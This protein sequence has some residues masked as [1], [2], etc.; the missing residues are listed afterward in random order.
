M[1]WILIGILTAIL[2]EIFLQLP[3][4]ETARGIGITA[5]KAVRILR[6]RGVSDHW[7]EKAS[8]AYA[9]KMMRATLVL[10]GGLG[11]IIAIA[12]ILSFGMESLAPGFG[13]ALISWPGLVVSLVVATLYVMLRK[14]FVRG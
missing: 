4:I 8:Q 3:L 7:K 2:V 9:G 14:R 5:R 11:V 10:A 13:S 6:A 1:I 12:V